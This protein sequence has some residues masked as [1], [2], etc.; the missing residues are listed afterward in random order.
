M[1]EHEATVGEVVTIE[2]KQYRVEKRTMKPTSITPIPTCDGCSL[3]HEP[4]SV[5]W[6]ARCSAMERDDGLYVKFIEVTK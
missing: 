6:N 5:C 1:S 2:G 3:Y 4:I